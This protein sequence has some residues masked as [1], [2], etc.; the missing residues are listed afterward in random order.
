MQ[1][2]AHATGDPLHQFRA[3]GWARGAGWYQREHGGL[4]VPFP[5]VRERLERLEEA[6]QICLQMW[7]DND[8]PYEGKHYRLAET[9]C[10]P[11]P[12][13]RPRPRILI[14]GGGERKTL[15][16]VA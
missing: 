14:G 8:G 4:G 7:S 13:Q 6:L 3:A 10:V 12:I 11:P 15:R 5:P 2:R 9:I 16:L 1:E